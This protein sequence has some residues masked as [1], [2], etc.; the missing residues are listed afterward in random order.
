MD[1]TK[2]KCPVYNNPHYDEEQMCLKHPMRML[3]CGNAGSGKTMLLLNIIRQ[4]SD[5]FDSIKIFTPNKQVPLY[6]FLE[7]VIATPA[8]EI[9]EDLEEFN[10][11]PKGQHLFVFDDMSL[12]EDQRNVELLFVR[13]RVLGVSVIYIS[14]SY[15][16]TPR[17]IRRCLDYIIP[18]TISSKRD[19]STIQIEQSLHCGG[20]ALRKM[21]PPTKD[22]T[23][24]LLID[25]NAT[26]ARRFRRNFGEILS[27]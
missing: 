5:T 3:I 13:A 6:E 21:I 22:I 19:L 17:V 23:N 10:K 1:I 2:Y 12:V 27:F 9:Y 26:D 11:Q 4:M 15:F 16:E 20:D 25:L 14:H 7:S 18:K 8:L 24:F